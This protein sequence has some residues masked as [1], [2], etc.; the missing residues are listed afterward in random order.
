MVCC[1][2]VWDVCYKLI[3]ALGFKIKACVYSTSLFSCWSVYMLFVKVARCSNKL[4]GR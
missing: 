4:V 2:R 1:V 3:V